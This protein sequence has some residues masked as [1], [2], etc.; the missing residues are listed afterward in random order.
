MNTGKYVFSQILD[1]VSEYEFEK[2]VKRYFGNYHV[3]YF[4]C[5]NQFVQLF[6]GQLKSL[7]SLNDICLVLKAHKGNFTIWELNSMWVYPNYREL[8]RNEIGKFWFIS[9]KKC[10]ST[11]CWLICS[12]FKSGQWNLFTW[13]N[14]N[15]IIDFAQIMQKK[16]DL[17][18]S[19]YFF[20]PISIREAILLLG[21]LIPNTYCGK[22]VVHADI[23]L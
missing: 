1:L 3:R 16:I 9:H 18:S 15:I 7:N 2:C 13:F 22:T 19:A 11:V 17:S 8:I 10:S 14:N 5:R 20:S 6:F 4:Y 23:Y 21:F 12:K